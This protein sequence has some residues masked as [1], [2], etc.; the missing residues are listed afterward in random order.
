MIKRYWVNPK[1]TQPV[2]PDIE[3]MTGIIELV[4]RYDDHLEETTKLKD[5]LIVWHDLREDP[6]DLPPLQCYVFISGRK[7]RHVAVLLPEGWHFLGNVPTFKI[8]EWAY[9]PKPPKE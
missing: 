6:D 9:I 4:V 7:N 2:L 3:P 5:S 1:Y 8:I